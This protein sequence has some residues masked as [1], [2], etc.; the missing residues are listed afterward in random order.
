MM[1]KEKRTLANADA[2][3]R[4]ARE[5]I[6]SLAV[7]SAQAAQAVLSVRLHHARQ[8]GESGRVRVQEPGLRLVG[9]R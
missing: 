3:I 9:Q 6:D 7:L 5:D 4:Q 8:P 2:A 1:P